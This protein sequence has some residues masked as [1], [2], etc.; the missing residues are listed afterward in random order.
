VQRVAG[1]ETRTSVDAR[2]T[3]WHRPVPLLFESLEA[4]VLMAVVTGVDPLAESHTALVSTA[5]SAT[6][7]ETINPATVSDQTFVVRGRQSGRLL[8]AR[9]DITS[10]WTPV[11]WS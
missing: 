8:T 3:T 2:R 10:A 1:T 9:G 6:F 4:K 5:V 7:D 11:G